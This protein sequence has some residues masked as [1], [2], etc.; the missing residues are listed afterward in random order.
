[1]VWTPVRDWPRH[2]K[3]LDMRL[4]G[5]KLDEIS[6][7]FGISRE[8]ARQML[9][10]AKWRLAYRVFKGVPYKMEKRRFGTVP[11]CDACWQKHR[12]YDPV[13]LREPQ[14]EI[15][16]FCDQPTRS[17]IYVRSALK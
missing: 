3:A 1:M 10:V 15:C 4:G 11:V 17:G 9:L 12:S 7:E 16:Y 13:R 6:A 2:A 5:A 8:R 14:E